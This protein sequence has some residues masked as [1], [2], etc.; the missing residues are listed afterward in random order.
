MPSPS[1]SLR[2]QPEHPPSMDYA[3]L[4]QH[5][6]EAAQ[7]LSGDIWSDY[8]EH[9]P[10]IT[11]LENLCYAI[12]ELGFKARLPIEDLLFG[13]GAGVFDARD[14]AMYPPEEVLPASPLTLLDYRKLLIDRL[15]AVRNAWVVPATQ[16]D[17]GIY[18]QG[19]YQV[20]LQLDPSHRADPVAVQAQAFALM[21]AHRNLCEDVDQ[22]TLLQP[23]PIQV[24][25]RIHISPQVVGESMLAKI[26]FA[27]SETLTPQI[28]FHTLD[29]QKE[30]PLDQLFEGP[31]PIH[32]FIQD[33][34]LLKSELEDLRTIHQSAL[35]QQIS[36]I[37]GVLSVEQ[38]Q[39]LIDG[40]PIKQETIRLAARHYPSLDIRALLQRP[41]FDEHFPI[42]LESGDIGY[43]LDLETAARSY[44]MLLA[45]HKQQ[46][47][48]P[49]ELE[50][51]LTQSERK[52]SDILAYHS[53]QEHFPEVYGLGEKGLPS[54]AGLLRRGRAKQLQGYLLMFEQLLANYLAQLVNVRHLFSTRTQVEQTYFYQPL[55]DLPGTA[56]LLGQDREAFSRKLA[57]LVFRY[58]HPVSRR[59]RIMDH[60]LARFGETFLSDAFN[61]LNRQAG[62]QDQDAFSEALLK[63]KLQYLQQYLPISRDRGKGHDYTQPTEGSQNMAGLRQRISLLF[64]ITD[65]D[66]TMLTRLLED[67]PAGEAGGKLSFSRKKVKTPAK[68]GFTFQWGSEDVLAQVLTHGIDRNL[69]RFEG[70]EKQVTIYFRFPEG[71]EQAVFQSES[72]EAAEEALTQLIH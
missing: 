43:Q 36:Q 35:I 21:R 65:L 63:A 11:I 30:V 10:G 53:I 24:S 60:L 37:D 39:L 27:L 51:V 33:E 22:I 31:L 59:H 32:G 9:D 72:I 6:I 54:R 18:V 52:L 29:S 64:G 58:D 8:N 5:G 44:D 34:D 15:P 2:R 1:A 16:S 38:F 25:A 62:G 20:L 28:R 47:E 55:F 70:G 48:R 26:L 12:T 71:E 19:L 4:R 45:R 13:K 46:Y 49:L 41:R 42:Q 61:A 56:A 40:E 50:T 14:H 69:Y 23:Q 17:R 7:R 66:R 67:K 3:R 68:D 57:E